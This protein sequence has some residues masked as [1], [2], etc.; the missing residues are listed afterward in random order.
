MYPNGI[1]DFAIRNYYKH[2]ASIRTHNFIPLIFN[3]TSFLSNT[4]SL[5]E[6]L[7]CIKN[8][9]EEMPKCYCGQH[10]KWDFNKKRYREFCSY[11]CA[12]RKVKIK[13]IEKRK[14]TNQKRYGGNAPA[15][16]SLIREKMKKSV[17]ERYE[18]L[19]SKDITNKKRQTCLVKYGVENPS[20]INEIKEKKM[21]TSLRNYGTKHPHQ[22]ERI[23]ERYRKTC[24]ERYGVDN[25]HKNINVLKKAQNTCIERYGVSNYSRQ[26]NPSAFAKIGDYSWLY[27]EYVNN[28]KTSRQIAKQLDIDK[29]TVCTYLLKYDIPMYRIVNFSKKAISWLE[30]IME[31]ENVFIKHA[32]NGG[33]YLIPGTKYYADGYCEETNTIYEFHGD[34]WHGNPK[35]FENN[36][37]CHP[38]DPFITAGELYEK[39]NKREE[40]IH[41]LGYNLVVIWENEWDEI[42]NKNP[43]QMV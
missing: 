10:V 37:Y 19:A 22:S 33:E 42:I 41:D 38:F 11:K 29:K 26:H 32:G 1:K 17:E 31:R 34:L 13:T 14:R 35:L 18:S 20:Q 25:P 4:S 40:M 15:C 43:S 6:R 9:L 36:E 30:Y 23:K 12:N 27:N 28:L 8:D 5:K 24:I 16:D 39:T 21:Q 2:S 7:F 3:L